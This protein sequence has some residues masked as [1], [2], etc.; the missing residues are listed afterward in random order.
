MKRDLEKLL[1]GLSE[2]S[3]N[4]PITPLPTSTKPIGEKAPSISENKNEGTI[5]VFGG[6]EQQQE[7]KK[8]EETNKTVSVFGTAAEQQA[9]ERNKTVSVFKGVQD[10]KNTGETTEEEHEENEFPDHNEEIHAPS[11]EPP[12]KNSNGFWGCVH[13]GFR[14][15]CYYTGYFCYKQKVRSKHI[16]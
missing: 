14:Y 13:N 12:R 3:R 6:L 10:K 11:H 8:E 4:E 15:S 1:S 9:D 16:D 5:S 2:A 7:E